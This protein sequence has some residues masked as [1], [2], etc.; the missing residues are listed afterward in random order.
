MWSKKYSRLHTPPSTFVQLFLLPHSAIALEDA[1]ALVTMEIIMLHRTL[2]KTS[3]QLT[4]LCTYNVRYVHPHIE[5]EGAGRWLRFRAARPVRGRRGQNYN[6]HLNTK[7]WTLKLSMAR[8]VYQFVNCLY[9]VKYLHNKYSWPVWGSAEP[10]LTATRNCCSL[11]K[12]TAMFVRTVQ[13]GQSTQKMHAVT[14][15]L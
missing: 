5:T 4:Y 2:A 12:Y 3:S 14:F 6:Y 13:R 10:L 9:L 11:Y 8:P 15:C 1:F 7:H